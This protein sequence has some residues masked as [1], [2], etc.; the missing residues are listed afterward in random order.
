MAQISP[1]VGIDVSKDRLDVS[2]FP[3][4]VAI[5]VANNEA[6]WRELGEWC[7]EL[8]VVTAGL[9]ASGGFEQGVARALQQRGLTVRLLNAFQVRSFAKAIGRLAKNDALDAAVIARFVATVPGRPLARRNPELE[10][11]GAVLGLRCQLVERL[12]AATHQASGVADPMLGRMCRR[13]LRGL[14][15]DIVLLDRRLAAIVAADPGLA[16]RYRLLCSVPGVGP[17]LAHTLLA[18]LPELGTIGR[19]Q[20]AALVGVVPYDFDSGKMKGKRCIWGGRS[21]L[22]RVL[23]MAALTASRHNPLLRAFR[24]RLDG[25]GKPP[26]VA[27]V[28]VMRKLL[29]TLNAMLR[30]GEEWRPA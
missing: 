14:K 26:K 18:W 13:Q 4:E 3:G 5:S 15:A 23:Y 9:E 25:A 29:V 19:K 8:S 7:L 17:V 6:G 16:K 24:Q 20:I 2:V 22:R 28:A 30:D 21:E 10:H 12:V 27:L 11:L 1:H